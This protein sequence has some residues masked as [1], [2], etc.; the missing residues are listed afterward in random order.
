MHG[1]PAYAEVAR[2]S[3]PSS[4][5]APQLQPTVIHSITA[6]CRASQSDVRPCPHAQ[7]S[8]LGQGSFGVTKLLR[9]TATGELVA[10]KFIERG[11]KVPSLQPSERHAAAQQS[12]VNHAVNVTICTP[13]Q[14]VRMRSCANNRARLCA[15]L[16]HGPSKR[17][18]MRQS[19]SGRTVERVCRQVNEYVER[20]LANHRQ[21]I[22]PHIIQFK[23][24]LPALPARHRVMARQCL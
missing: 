9:H 20:E 6:Q 17:T 7:V 18:C 24:V 19:N 1:V 12:L 15:L 4:P 11:P 5:A 8:E 13:D 23:E 3:L 2:R 14:R 22:H 21:L 16:S 10:V